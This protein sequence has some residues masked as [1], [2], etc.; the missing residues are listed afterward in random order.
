MKLWSLEF[1]VGFMEINI[2]RFDCSRPNFSAR[3][4]YEARLNFYI[5]C[6]HFRGS[7]GFH[8]F[9]WITSF[10]HP[11]W[12][13]SRK[14]A[15]HEIWDLRSLRLAV[16]EFASSFLQLC[17]LRSRFRWSKSQILVK[18]VLISKN[19]TNTI[20][21]IVLV[22]PRRNELFCAF[23]SSKPAGK[24]G[25]NALATCHPKFQTS[26]FHCDV[27]P[28][29]LPDGSRRYRENHTGYLL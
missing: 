21:V 9:W 15:A 24:N 23:F 22:F 16:A 5:C 4:L 10:T 17:K 18:I 14:T 13:R 20:F 6:A 28:T 29:S 12:R 1:Q 2:R 27:E 26:S 19:S 8:Q 11:S 7:R 3:K 25:E